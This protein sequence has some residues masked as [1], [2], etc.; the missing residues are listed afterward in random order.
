MNC[1]LEHLALPH[2]FKQVIYLKAKS[3]RM[4]PFRGRRYEGRL[5]TLYANVRLG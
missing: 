1:K 2:A 5:L 3:K 4:T